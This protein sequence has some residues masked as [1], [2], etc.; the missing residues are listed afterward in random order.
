MTAQPPPAGWYPD[1]NGGPGQMYWDGQQWQTEVLATPPPAQSGMFIP[2]SDQRPRHGPTGAL[3]AVIVAIV[4][5]VV[6]T[7][8][9]VIG[10]VLR[11][12]RTGVT[13]QPSSTSQPT[14]T[15]A[16]TTT[17]TTQITTA[18]DGNQMIGHYTKTETTSDGNSGTNEWY[19]TSCGDGC[20]EVASELGGQPFGQ[21]NLVNGQWTMTAG[22]DAKCADGTD[23]PNANSTYYT[24]DP[25]TLTGTARIT[26]N[27]PACGDPAGYQFTN[28]LQFT[29]AP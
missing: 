20:A 27:V 8:V 17:T 14:I 18:P 6:V 13:A 21:A 7:A 23:V 28:T 1:P 19:F 29:K 25:N 10:L 26:H 3:I 16:T 9:V 2:P 24:W 12:H 5:V 11:N 4:A 22:A 15:A